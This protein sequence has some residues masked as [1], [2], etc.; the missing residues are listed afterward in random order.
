MS[1]IGSH[2]DT[3]APRDVNLTF[4][5]SQAAE[6]TITWRFDASVVLRCSY[7]LSDNRELVTLN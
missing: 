5:T 1:A 7:W 3:T 4:I 2:G 6:K